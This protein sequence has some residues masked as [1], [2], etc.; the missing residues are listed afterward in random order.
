MLKHLAFFA[1]DVPQETRDAEK[2]DIAVDGKHAAD[3]CAEVLAHCFYRRQEDA[4]KI[5]GEMH[6]V[7]TNNT[8]YM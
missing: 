7:G 1:Y 6:S 4:G 8:K 5:T 2:R 3:S